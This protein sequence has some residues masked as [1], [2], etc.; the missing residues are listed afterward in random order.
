MSN[1]RR[2][3]PFLQQQ[4]Q[5]D[6]KNVE[7]DHLRNRYIKLIISSTL[8]QGIHL[9]DVGIKIPD[10]GGEYDIYVER[11]AGR[12]Y[13]DLML[14]SRDGPDGNKNWHAIPIIVE[15]K[16]DTT[17]PDRATAQTINTGYLYNL[18][19]IM[20]DG[21]M[22]NL[23]QS[24]NSIKD[25]I[26]SESDFQAVLQGLFYGYTKEIAKGNTGRIIKVFPEANL[27]REGID[28]LSLDD[29]ESPRSNNFNIEPSNSKRPRPEQRKRRS[30][31]NADS[32]S[33]ESIS[34]FADKLFF[35]DEVNNFETVSS[36]SAKLP[37]WPFR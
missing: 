16:A 24:L 36:G 10:L 27:S 21:I 30:I 15:L 29:L 28:T 14:L 9:T 8:I 32:Y 34:N 35:N 5:Q 31:N 20:M 1:P 4:M 19:N 13:S 3:A 2:L 12:G 11:I 22:D 33:N 18:N 7:R 23:S 37:F 26:N 6:G 25:T 17:S